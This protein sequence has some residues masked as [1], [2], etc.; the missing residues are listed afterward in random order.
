MIHKTL[1]FFWGLQFS[2]KISKECNKKSPANPKLFF[3]SKSEKTITIKKREKGKIFGTNKKKCFKSQNLFF[4]SKSQKSIIIKK[5]FSKKLLKS[6]FFCSK[7]ALANKNKWHEKDYY[8]SRCSLCM[9]VL[10]KKNVNVNE[11]SPNGIGNGDNTG[12]AITIK[13]EFV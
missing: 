1:F 9:C 5:V 3:C 12:I 7:S 6:T 2:P 11:N 4:C 13:M 8:E 10:P